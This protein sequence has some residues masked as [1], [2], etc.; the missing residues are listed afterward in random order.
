MSSHNFWLYLTK[1]YVQNTSRTISQW[2]GRSGGRFIHYA[3]AWNEGTH[4]TSYSERVKCTSWIWIN[5]GNGKTSN[6]RFW[7]LDDIDGAKGFV[8]DNQRAT[9][10]AL[11]ENKIAQLG[12]IACTSL[13]ID[14]CVGSLFVVQ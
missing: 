9:C 4:R 14:N 6:K 3:F 10:L 2:S 12:A 13:Q 1:D 8:R 5:Y 7:T 11:I